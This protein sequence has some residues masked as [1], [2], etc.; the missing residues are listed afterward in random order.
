MTEKVEQDAVELLPCPFCGHPANMRQL[1]L[2]GW[3]IH[4]SRISTYRGCLTFGDS[5]MAEEEMIMAWNTRTNGL[6]RSE[7]KI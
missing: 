1:G 4:C 5:V 7:R 3:R 2:D 6:T